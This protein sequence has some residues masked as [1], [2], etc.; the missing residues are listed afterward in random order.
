[1]NTTLIDLKGLKMKIEITH[2]QK[3]KIAIE[4]LKSCVE[5]I[6]EYGYISRE[7]ELKAYLRVISDNMYIGDFIEY[8]KDNSL[9]KYCKKIFKEYGY[10][11]DGSSK[12]DEEDSNQQKSY[13]D[14]GF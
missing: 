2:E 8:A 12:E 13:Q 3:Q 14:W 7:K 6:L 10:N 11:A 1:M 9:T 4:Y 5:D